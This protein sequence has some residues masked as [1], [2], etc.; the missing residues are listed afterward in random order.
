[1]GEFGEDFKMV[2]SERLTKLEDQERHSEL[3]FIY[4]SKYIVKEDGP[5]LHADGTKIRCPQVL[6]EGDQ[7]PMN[8]MGNNNLGVWFVEDSSKPGLQ[9][10]VVI[11]ALHTRRT[12]MPGGMPFNCATSEAL[13][14]ERFMK[15]VVEKEKTGILQ[16][17]EIALPHQLICLRE[18]DDPENYI[19]Y[20][21]GR[22]AAGESL[23]SL[24]ADGANAL[25][26]DNSDAFL[27]K[28]QKRH[29]IAQN[30]TH[31]GNIF[32]DPESKKYTLID[33]FAAKSRFYGTTYPVM[34]VDFCDT[35]E[36]GDY[37]ADR[38]K[39]AKTAAEKTAVTVKVS[40]YSKMDATASETRN[41]GEYTGTDE[42]GDY[43]A[44]RAKAAKTAPEK[45]A[46]CD[47]V[48][49]RLF[50]LKYP[51]DVDDEGDENQGQ[52]SMM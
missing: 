33:R 15:K 5:L 34:G 16:D 14:M 6:L 3:Q 47:E 41:M 51:G 37:F 19:V 52:C 44:D 36:E 17:P 40:T 18:R 39:A 10:Q 21:V 13:R 12:H 4:L 30:D 48:Y 20:V 49:A 27:R 28:I 31:D 42:E 7:N 9:N 1:M 32:F 35:D 29:G 43:F 8:R 25:A 50:G 22:R 38:A 45:T 23:E 2:R 46:A 11:K 24:A 26:K